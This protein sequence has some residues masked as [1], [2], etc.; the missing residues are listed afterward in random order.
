MRARQEYSMGM[1]FMNA[2]A[3]AAE[4]LGLIFA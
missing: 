3:L 4:D 2:D 1:D